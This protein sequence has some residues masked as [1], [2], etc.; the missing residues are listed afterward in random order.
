MNIDKP[1][2]V[3]QLLFEG[4]WPTSVAF[5]EDRQHLAAGNRGGDIYVWQL[6]AEPPSAEELNDEQ[7][8]KKKEAGP[9][10]F[11]PKFKLK[12]HTNGITHLIAIDGGKRLISA[13]LDHTIR[14]WD[15]SQSPSGSETVILDPQTRER[16][17][18]YGSK[19]EKE[20][21]RNAPG[22][23][24]QV[25]SESRVLQGHKNWI[26][27]LAISAD[28][29]RL[30]SGDDSCLSIVWDL[31]SLEQVTS[32]QGYDRVWV[33]SAALSPDGSLAF[34]GEYA[35][36]RGDFDRPAAQA[37]LWNASDGTLR[38]DLLKLWTPDVKDEDR[39]DS[40]GY[41]QA[42]GKLLKSGLVC[43][44]FSP[45][46]KLLAAGQGG[47]TDTGKVHLIEV[48]SGKIERSVAGHQYGVCDCKF[49]ADGKYILSCGRD[50]TVQ[51][52]QVADGKE[53]A[54]LGESRGGQFKDWLPAV[55]IAPDQQWVAAA[56]IGGY[57]Q[58]W[59]LA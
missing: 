22:V 19:E 31:T 50:T 14:I 54:K 2:H 41:G 55:A 58:L 34:T 24:V 21:I 36:P 59:K 16:D 4:E 10:N 46:G 6:P 7:K 44:A 17:S 42:W 32:W 43:A 26:Q 11:A 28:G 57:V 25:L 33:T 30:L 27:A 9:P 38:L 47:E 45:D 29:R 56:D 15:L 5:L 48:E 20:A 23:E 35:A 52:C 40:Y 12:G 37:R 53:I 3:W 39:N 8:K 1:E 13:S 49:S 51:I 18:Q